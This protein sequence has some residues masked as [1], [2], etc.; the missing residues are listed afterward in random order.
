MSRRPQRFALPL[1]ASHV[2]HAPLRRF[3]FANSNVN[4][5]NLDKMNPH[6]VPDVVSLSVTSGKHPLPG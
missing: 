4:D 3:D 5:E 6:H 1:P 2:L